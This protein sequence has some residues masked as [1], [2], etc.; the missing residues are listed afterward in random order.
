MKTE[1]ITVRISKETKMKIEN[2]AHKN[3]ITISKV[4]ENIIKKGIRE[5]NDFRRQQ[6]LS[7]AFIQLLTLV[8]SLEDEKRKDLESVIGDIQK[9]LI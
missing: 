5:E 8:R 7:S 6:Q 9:C 3:S 1:R 2:I 4:V